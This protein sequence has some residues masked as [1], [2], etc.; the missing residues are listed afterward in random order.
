MSVAV[1][2]L[3]LHRSAGD[4]ILFPVYFMKAVEENIN[5]ILSEAQLS[6]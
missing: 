6:A 1:L 5:G 4:P 3:F 2:P